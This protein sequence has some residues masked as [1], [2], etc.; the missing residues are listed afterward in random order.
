[1]LK[2]TE[3]LEFHLKKSVRAVVTK[4]CSE[5]HRVIWTNELNKYLHLNWELSKGLSQLNGSE[6]L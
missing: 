6:N 2:N 3:W 5:A 4:I 1:M